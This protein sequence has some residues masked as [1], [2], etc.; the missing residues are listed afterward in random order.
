[1][2]GPTLTGPHV[3]ASVRTCGFAYLPPPPPA[4]AQPLSPL[5]RLW[6]PLS[7]SQPPL[8]SPTTTT[9]IPTRTGIADLV[10]K[11]VIGTLSAALLLYTP[12]TKLP[13]SP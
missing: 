6:L 13:R 5:A 9:P 10:L 11:L 3:D 7:L 1:M 8:T 4:S 12:Q 2:V